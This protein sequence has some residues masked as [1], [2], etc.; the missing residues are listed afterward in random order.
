M[1]TLRKFIRRF[2]ARFRLNKRIVCEE[3]AGLDVIDYH[4]YTD[5]DPAIPWHCALFTCSRCGKKFFF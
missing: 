2:I 5:A 1:K 3:S 4:D